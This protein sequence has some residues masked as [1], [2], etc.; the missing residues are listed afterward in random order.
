MISSRLWCRQTN[1]LLSVSYI[2]IFNSQQNKKRTGKLILIGFASGSSYLRVGLS[3]K[4]TELTFRHFSNSRQRGLDPSRYEPS[5]E[6]LEINSVCCV[7]GSI[8]RCGV[9]R[10]TEYDTILLYSWI[11]HSQTDDFILQTWRWE[12]LKRSE[13]LSP[14]HGIPKF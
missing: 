7:A 1:L 12:Y 10:S 6:S 13:F 5:D 14:F 11:C 3:D 2:C 4:A 9:Y 8:L